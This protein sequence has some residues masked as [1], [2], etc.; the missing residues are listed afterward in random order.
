MTFHPG[1]LLGGIRISIP[2]G[3]IKFIN[4]NWVIP[5]V[6][7]VFFSAISMGTV[8]GEPK[9]GDTFNISGSIWNEPIN[10]SFDTN[11]MSIKSRNGVVTGQMI[12]SDSGVYKGSIYGTGM[13]GIEFWWKK[14]ISFIGKFNG[15]STPPRIEGQCYLHEVK[16]NSFNF[17]SKNITD[18]DDN[19]EVA[20]SAVLQEGS[21]M[22]CW[23]G[24]CFNLP[25][26]YPEKTPTMTLNHYPPFPYIERISGQFSKDNRQGGDVVATLLDKDGVPMVR[27]KVYFF[28]ESGSGLDRV[29]RYPENP[30]DDWSQIYS[31][32]KNA[33]EDSYLGSGFTNKKGI[34]TTN[35]IGLNCIDPQGFSEDLI[36]KGIIKGNIKAVVFDERQ[37]KVRYESSIPVEFRYMGKIVDIKKEGLQKI[38]GNVRVKRPLA[39]PKFDFTI[40]EEGFEVM[41]GDIVNVDGDTEIKILLIDATIVHIKVPKGI[42]SGDG[43]LAIQDKSI[44]LL[45][46]AHNAGFN[47][48]LDKVTG[49]LFGFTAGKGVDFL[50]E[51]VPGIETTTKIGI[52]IRDSDREVDLNTV[53]IIAKIQINGKAIVDQEG[54]EIRVYDFDGSSRVN[55]QYG[56]TSVPSRNRVAVISEKGFTVRSTNFNPE[57]VESEFLNIAPVLPQGFGGVYIGSRSNKAKGQVQ[58]PVELKGVNKYMGPM[59]LVIRYDP[60]VL[61]ATGVIHGSRTD[62]SVIHYNISDGLIKIDIPNLRGFRGDGTLAYLKFNVTGP[63]GSYSIISIY[64][65]LFMTR[66]HEIINMDVQYGTFKVVGTGENIGD[67]NGDGLLTSIDALTALQMAVGRREMDI[68][69]DI[70]RDGV[71]NS[72]DAR[73]ILK[74]IAEAG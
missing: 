70:N 46:T 24:H 53:G 65:P 37:K 43:F 19:K 62:N 32:I 40:V 59:E 56:K 20:C 23:F 72:F 14:D 71:V 28:S 68:K 49:E 1:V 33:K 22:G 25:V 57:Q 63:R 66:D 8:Q 26:N 38:S 34:V 44:V 4:M 11:K 61:L 42:Q 64:D 12:L 30:P 58:I 35:Y 69:M 36:N 2:S 41:P 60:K 50:V 54:D 10:N 21:L 67:Y 48:G 47:L 31:F 13:D 16:K 7:L 18:S 27:Q 45:S 6:F 52:D 39:N 74:M 5:L 73:E 15:N 17:L 51:Q 9:V 29:L 55:T 3:N